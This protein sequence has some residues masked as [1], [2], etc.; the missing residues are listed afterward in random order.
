MKLVSVRSLQLALVAGVSLSAATAGRAQLAYGVDSLGTLFN[1][2][3]SAPATTTTVGNL[4]FVP[5]GID[6]RTGTGMLY[7]IDIG[8]SLSRLYTVDVASGLATGIGAGFATAGTVGGL[9]YNLGSGTS[10]GFDFNPTTLQADGS[11]RIRLT[12]N[13]GTNLRLHSATGG[14]AAVD[15]SI[16]GTIGAVAYINNAT[17]TIG[18]AT[19]LYDI[20]YATDSLFLQNPPNNGTLNLVGPLGVNVGSNLAFDILTSLTGGDSGIA[21]DTGYFVN[22]TGVGS[23]TLYSLN[24]G[25]GAAAQL[26]V[27]TRDFT[28]GFAIASPVPEPAHFG[29]GAA[30]VLLGVAVFRRRKQARAVVAR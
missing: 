16:A 10:F 18:G 22:T 2:N 13:D 24:L 4:G 27:L 8:P 12:A 23:A 7:A 29:L 1:F 25:T 5:E 11:I 3:L 28:G 14:I 20:D 26:G 15:G 17:A 19:A 9:S 30:A 6:F 21:G